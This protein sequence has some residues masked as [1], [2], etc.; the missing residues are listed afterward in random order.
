M[1]VQQKFILHFVN[2]IEITERGNSQTIQLM[3]PA[4]VDQFGEKFGN[5][6]I[7]DVRCYNKD[8]IKLPDLMK[9]RL[10]ATVNC[11]IYISSKKVTLQSGKEFYQPY[12][13]LKNIEIIKKNEDHTQDSAS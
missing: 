11:S 9:I 10:G 8:L 5:D 13:T 7:Y 1:Y 4:K 2:A 12:I 3:L 6:T